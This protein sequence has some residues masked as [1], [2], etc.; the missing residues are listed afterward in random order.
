MADQPQEGQG[1]AL[2]RSAGTLTKPTSRGPA[3]VEAL[4]DVSFSVE[5]GQRLG[6]IGHNGSGKSTL[7]RVLAGVYEPTQGRVQVDGR[8][9]PMFNIG[10]GM[11]RE[12]TGR[13]NIILR[14]LMNGLTHEQARAKVDEILEFS[15]LGH[16]IDMPVRNYSSGMAMRLAFATS[17]AFSPEILLLDEWIGA[18]DQQ[19]QK[20]AAERMRSLVDGAGITVIA[21]HRP[22]ILKRVCTHALWLDAGHVR[23][24]GELEDVL[25][26][27]NDDNK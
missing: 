8:I 21:S 27:F 25:K 22:A 16:F 1:E 9:A 26:A 23:H 13:R 10:L 24:Y 2:E 7:L 5:P 6:L 11:R 17:T 3:M 4:K 15:E 14:G 19:F 20:K 18:G 12:S